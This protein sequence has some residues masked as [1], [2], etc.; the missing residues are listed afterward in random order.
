ME[1]NREIEL[2]KITLAG[3]FLNVLLIVLKFLAGF[4]SGSQVIIADGVHSLSDFISDAF[5]L[6]GIKISSKPPD[7]THNYGHYKFENLFTILVGFI[8]II[9]ALLLSY[10]AIN[11]IITKE[12]I[13]HE[14][15]WTAFIIALFSIVSK[16]YIFKKTITIGRKHNSEM[17][18]ANAWHHRSDSLS[19]I[20]AAIGI[21][22]SMVKI[23][24]ADPIGTMVVSAIILKTGITLVIKNTNFLMDVSIDKTSFESIIKSIKSIPEVIEYHNLKARYIGPYIYCE[25]HI[26]VDP[27]LTVRKAHEI[28]HKVKDEI[29]KNVENVKDVQ[30]HIE[31]YSKD[32]QFIL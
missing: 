22:G 21:F 10:R 9:A 13:S 27:N 18:I 12:Y 29:M 20:A 28:S 15:L 26:L 25:L 17:I 11:S 19:S 1:M 16:E 4:L 23:K 6:I 14:N 32:K 7:E 30:I 24:I 3:V 2:K 31:P 8:L 5:V